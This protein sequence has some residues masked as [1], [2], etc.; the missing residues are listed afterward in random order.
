MNKSASMFRKSALDRLAS[1]EQLDQVIE[2][3]SYRAWLAVVGL[4]GIS[5]SV[6]VWAYHG[7]VATTAAG[8]GLLVRQGRVLSVPARSV[9][10]VL[11]IEV[12]TGDHVTRGQHVAT[13]AQEGLLAEVQ[14]AR[15]SLEERRRQHASDM[16]LRKAEA[17]LAAQ[18]LQRERQGVRRKI[19]D[20][21]AEAA[22]AAEQIPVTDKL[23]SKGLVTE[24]STISARQDHA[25]ILR[26]VDDLNARLV[27]LDA[28]E[29]AKK[30][31]LSRL[32]SE[33][34]LE[35]ANLERNLEIMTGNLSMSQNVVSPHSGQVLEIKVDRGAAVINGTPILSIQPDSDRLQALVYL[36]ARAA[37]DVRRGMDVQLSPAHVRREEFG[38]IIGTVDYVA[39][40]P[41]TDVALMR[42]FQNQKLVA[43][44]L[45]GEPVTEVRVALQV[46]DSTPTGFRWS[47]S[48]GPSA[49]LSSGTFC[50]AA[51]VVRRQAPITLFV[52]FLKRVAGIA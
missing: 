43:T 17:D 4:L 46:D 44:L 36:S 35:I 51:V 31:E 32:D 10:V 9:G 11:S 33:G 12:R 2:V 26:S 24:Q 29:F 5:V 3:T 6:L 25:R 49:A 19:E 39:D 37:K 50:D 45:S 41:T 42:N 23:F 21:E 1:P 38:Y 30:S 27:Q 8:T 40:Y 52:P 34:R 14:S 15:Q 28:H 48:T 20:L 7:A 47:S 18:A 13:V 22:L 16:A